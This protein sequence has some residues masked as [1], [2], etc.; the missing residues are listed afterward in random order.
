[1]H[2]VSEGSQCEKA[3]YYMTP[4]IPLDKRQRKDK[5]MET[6]KWLVVGEEGRDGQ[7]EW[8]GLLG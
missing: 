8:R 4:T 3:A 2:L 5:A 7:M 6:A 1:M